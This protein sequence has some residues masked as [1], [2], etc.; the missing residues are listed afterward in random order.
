M[1]DSLLHDLKLAL[2]ALVR[3]PGFA[4][5]A[6]VTL[7]VGI[8]ANATLFTWM[9]AVLLEPLPGTR[10]PLQLAE[11][12][13]TSRSEAH[14]SMSYPDYRDL[15]DGV[16]VVLRGGR[17][18]RAA[19][20]PRHRRRAR[21][22]LDPDRV[23]QLL[24]GPRG[25]RVSGPHPAARGRPGARPGRRDRP[26]PRPLAAPLRE[27]PRRGGPQGQAQR[28]RLHRGRRGPPRVPRL[29]HRADLRSVD[30][31]GHAAGAGAGRGPPPEP[32]PTLARRAGAARSRRHGRAR[33]G[34]SSRPRPRSSAATS[35]PPTTAWALRPTASTRARAEP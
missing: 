18:E 34:P 8:G 4:T 25:A 29:D 5:L 19:R 2:R 27:R 31:H 32:R 33:L 6:V 35:P 7:A 17:R 20:E 13:G 23:R 9:N 26:R 1:M 22:D 10:A 3:N 14:I 24:R 16:T 12:L 15:R 21:A 28:P 30:A 11:V